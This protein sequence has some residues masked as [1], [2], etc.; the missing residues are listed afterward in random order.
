M[1]GPVSMWIN[2]LSDPTP[3]QRKT[4]DRIAAA[5]GYDK[6]ILDKG[7][8]HRILWSKDDQL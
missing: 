4:L 7:A 2:E 8:R 5:H 6:I 1:A 3:A